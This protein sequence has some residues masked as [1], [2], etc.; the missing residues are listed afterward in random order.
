MTCPLI[1]LSVIE[2]TIVT[3]TRTAGRDCA[4]IFTTPQARV[5]VNP[6]GSVKTAMPQ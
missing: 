4:T 6:N 1:L 2:D 5:I 3:G